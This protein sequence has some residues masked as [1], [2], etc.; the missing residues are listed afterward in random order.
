MDVLS[1][2]FEVSWKVRSV[3]GT[4]W[5]NLQCIM[6]LAEEGQFMSQT[7]G[8]GHSVFLTEDFAKARVTHLGHLEQVPYLQSPIASA[9]EC[10]YEQVQVS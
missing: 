3:G 7:T 6:N 2:S 4:S 8:K 10:P 5:G 1:S 9:Y